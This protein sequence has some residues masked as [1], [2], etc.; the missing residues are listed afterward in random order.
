MIY[1]QG[2]NIGD[3][4]FL[5]NFANIII[6][7]Y[8]ATSIKKT[9][10]PNITLTNKLSCMVLKFEL[11]CPVN[12]M[13]TL[14]SVCSCIVYDILSISYVGFSIICKIKIVNHQHVV[15]PHGTLFNYFLRNNE[16]NNF[17]KIIIVSS[18]NLLI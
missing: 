16:L 2:I 6:N 1:W 15:E 5:R 18:K 7:N 11:N 12:R 10:S 3:W 8:M 13:Y 9:N 4:Q 14:I 17:N